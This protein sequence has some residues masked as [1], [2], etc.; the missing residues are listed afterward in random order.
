MFVPE[1]LRQ[2]REELKITQSDMAR[3]LCITRQSYFA[4]DNKTEYS[5]Y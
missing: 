3:R 5:K 1:V 4:W 2:R